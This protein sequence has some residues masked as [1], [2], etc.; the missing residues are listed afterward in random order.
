MLFDNSELASAFPSSVR[1]EALQAAT[2][3]PDTRILG[4]S[5]SV[6]VSNE[7][8]K[9]PFRLY[10]D[11][12]LIQS[13]SV[14]G[15]QQ[16]LVD[17]LLTRHSDGLVREQHLVRIVGSDHVWVPPFVV[18]LVGEYVVEILRVIHQNLHSLDSSSYV[19][20]LRANPHFL[21]TTEQRVMSYWNCYYRDQK[22]EEYVGFK[23]LKFFQALVRKDD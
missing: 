6:R 3:F 10:N 8:V 17:C 12:T 5:F 7:D 20:F 16:E 2:A 9:I 21:A 11:P 18:Q 13:T 19:S 22:R 23:L 15:I 1:H 14:S 4:E